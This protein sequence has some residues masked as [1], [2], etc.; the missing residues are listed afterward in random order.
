MITSEKAMEDDKELDE[1]A[2]TEETRP[3]EPIQ[4]VPAWTHEGRIAVG[5]ASKPSRF[6]LSM[7]PSRS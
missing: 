4:D 3:A 6:R 1:Q 5:A 7:L 2:R